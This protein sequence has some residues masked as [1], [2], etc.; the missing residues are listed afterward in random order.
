MKCVFTIISIASFIGN[1]VNMFAFLFTYTARTMS[2]YDRSS[3]RSLAL[4]TTV[5]VAQYR[6]GICRAPAPTPTGRMILPEVRLQANKP[7]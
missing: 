6:S 5:P 1:P 4:R 7:I 2:R 3:H